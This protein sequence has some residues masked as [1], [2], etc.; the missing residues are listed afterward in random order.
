MPFTV[1]RSDARTSIP[2][3]VLVALLLL[4][5]VPAAADDVLAVGPG[6]R[7]LGSL[8][9]SDDVDT[10]VAHGLAGER[11]RVVVTGR[12]GLRPRVR[13]LD[14]RTGLV[15]AEDGDGTSR[16]ARAVVELPTSG[17]YRA[18]IL[19]ADGAPGD[20]RVRVGKRPA[21]RGARTA[22]DGAAISEELFVLAGESLRLVARAKGQD[23]DPPG[24]ALSGDPLPEDW[25][26]D[27]FEKGRATRI[28]ELVVERTGVVRIDVGGAPSTTSLRLR[29]SVR[30]PRRIVE[31]V[32]LVDARTSPADG[33]TG[34][35]SRRPVVV[36]FSD[37]MAFDGDHGDAVSLSLV[38]PDGAVTP[39]DPADRWTRCSADGLRL[40]VYP[41]PGTVPPGATV[42]LSLDGDALHDRRGVPADLDGDGIA[43][44]M[45]VA[46]WSTL[47][48]DPVEDTVLCGRVLASEYGDGGVNVP[49]EG[50]HVTVDGLPGVE[51]YTEADGSFQ[52]EPVPAGRVFVHIDGAPAVA[53]PGFRY[54]TVGKA[55]VSTAGAVTNVGTVH[56]PALAD[57]LLVP[58]SETE[59]TTVRMVPEQ[60]AALEQ[61]DPG[62]AAQLERVE[63]EVPPGNLYHVDGRP[64]GAVGVAPVAPDRLPGRLP[65][66]LAL[67][68]VI[69]IQTDGASRF[70][71]P[72]PATFPN[73]PDPATGATLPPGAKSALWS[74]DHD[75]ARF[76]MVGGMTVSDDGLTI[77]TDAGVGI[78]APGWHGPA[79][80]AVIELLPQI[81]QCDNQELAYH[82]SVLYSAGVDLAT[83]MFGWDKSDK[84]IAKANK[85]A[86]AARKRLKK[87]AGQSRACKDLGLLAKSTKSTADLLGACLSWPKKPLQKAVDKAKQVFAVGY[88]GESF[89]ESCLG[90]KA[91][92]GGRL[93]KALAQGKIFFESYTVTTAILESV[94]GTSRVKNFFL[95]AGTALEKLDAL[96]CDDPKQLVTV[97]DDLAR[98]LDDLRDATGGLIDELDDVP[99][100]ELADAFRPGRQAVRNLTRFGRALSKGAEPPAGP[101]YWGFSWEGG[102]IR[103]V[104]QGTW[105]Q[106]VPPNRTVGVVG[107]SPVDRKVV[108]FDAQ[109]GDAGST[110]YA[111]PAFLAPADDLDDTDGDGIPDVAEPSVG[112]DPADPDTDGDGIGDL[113][114]LL[115]GTDPLGGLVAS[116]GIVATAAVQGTPVDVAADRG[117]VVVATT[118]SLE[119]FSTFNGLAPAWLASVPTG[120]PNTRL[121][122][123]W[124]LC[125]VS[126]A[127]DGLL[128][129]DLSDP[130]A[131]IVRS[132][133][134]GPT[135]DFSAFD[136]VDGFVVASSTNEK[137]G[138]PDHPNWLQVNA[139]DGFTG[140]R[141]QESCSPTPARAFFAAGTDLVF[142]TKQQLDGFRLTPAGWEDL[143]YTLPNGNT[144]ES[145]KNAIDARTAFATRDRLY[146]VYHHG[147]EL[148]SLDELEDLERLGTYK[149]N[150]LQFIDLEV[151]EGPVGLGLA[152]TNSAQESTR[153]VGVYDVS[154]DSLDARDPFFWFQTPGI[155]RAQAMQG[156][157]LYVVDEVP[158][159]GLLH[160]LNG[161][162]VDAAGQGPEVALE[163]SDWPS[164]RGLSTAYLRAEADD[165]VITARVEFHVDGTLA[166]VDHA[167]PFE[168][169]WSAPA[170]SVPTARTFAARAVD[171]AGNV[172]WSAEMSATY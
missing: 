91:K 7:V 154:D 21:R 18:E 45:L 10:L 92:D 95:L 26:L 68:I 67:P 119:V 63:L 17:A 151:I 90:L 64:G 166:S 39:L 97:D 88:E 15:L 24:V 44:G 37:P 85:L 47:P 79:P 133:L 4:L 141:V 109:T 80:G 54:P 23:P 120:G 100:S 60:L 22:V 124:P 117:L 43:G 172:A 150:P 167:P 51:A 48:I 116:L 12:G 96:V 104:S 163:V 82:A 27:V 160:A 13:F 3:R 65:A 74:F 8:E 139:Y 89:T 146:V 71:V 33:E 158:G 121:A 148:W 42:E 58:L 9:S 168:A 5:V 75:A 36:T 162:V 62:L 14:N 38:D 35:T 93:D 159:G 52:L 135:G 72:V 61:A 98:S 161:S 101:V 115:G 103:A 77:T 19:S 84:C 170:G 129:V 138:C 86:Y 108:S 28:Q 70:D 142:L 143:S 50:V 107:F 122:F 31:P 56:L 127:D 2:L 153:A 110:A 76:R 111:G 34:V 99:L 125:A 132:R 53:P 94:A 6:A 152:S 169:R 66:G 105:T 118:G 81:L 16:R 134:G 46:R 140:E 155:V 40:S 165:D 137:G 78:L 41:S 59:P 87:A 32:T 102:T 55:W 126:R 1:L 156:G 83:S 49:I 57:Q 29:W 20:Y 11:T 164:W 147:Y 136:V 114:E 123:E 145:L 157:L 69:T 171:L 112:T 144:T 128:V 130:A 149:K 131:P 25:E 30:P 73:L 113:D 106:S